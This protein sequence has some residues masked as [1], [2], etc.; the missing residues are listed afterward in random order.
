MI[1]PITTVALLDLLEHS[2]SR[3]AVVAIC[4]WDAVVVEAVVVHLEDQRVLVDQVDRVEEDQKV[5]VD[6]VVLA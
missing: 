1:V 4:D 5:L 3:L 2:V 6:Q